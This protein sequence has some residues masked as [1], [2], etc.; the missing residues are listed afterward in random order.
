MVRVVVIIC[1]LRNR[2]DVLRLRVVAGIVLD[3]VMGLSRGLVS[4]E[5]A[6]ALLVEDDDGVDE[7]TDEG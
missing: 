2:L 3:Q 1:W 5:R 4:A 7:K 6:L